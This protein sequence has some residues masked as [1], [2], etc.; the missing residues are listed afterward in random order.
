MKLYL[1][2]VRKTVKRTERKVDAGEVIEAFNRSPLSRLQLMLVDR[3]YW[4]I[5]EQ[6]WFDILNWSVVDR[7]KYR[8]ERQDCDDFAKILWGEVA[9]KFQLN[10][11]GLVLDFSGGHAYSAVVIDDN[12][13]LAVAAVEPQSDRTGVAASGHRAY[14]ARNGLVIF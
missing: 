8:A 13:R 2:D 1:R 9:R 6:S 4:V 14:A 7:I 5:P 3:D 12:G 11:I 10:S